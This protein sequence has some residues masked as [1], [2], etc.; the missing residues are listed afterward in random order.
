MDW[1]SQFKTSVDRELASGLLDSLILVPQST[2]LRDIRALLEAS[3]H[4]S[5]HPLGL[6]AAREVK[7][8]TYFPRDKRR[9]PTSV[10]GRD[11]GSEGM[12]AT[13]ITD[14]CRER[15]TAF[16]NHP[17]FAKLKKDACDRIIIVDDVS[18]SG[19]RVAAMMRAIRR[20]PTFRSWYS[21]AWITFGIV[22]YAVTQSAEDF[23]RKAA[24]LR[25]G[26]PQLHPL[27]V[28]CAQ[29]PEWWPRS[30]S[31]EEEKAVEE[32]CVTYGKEHKIP[33]K[34]HKGYR[35][36]MAR[37]VFE[38]SCPNN[39]PGLLW[40][41]TRTWRPLFPNRSVPLSLAPLFDSGSDPSKQADRARAILGERFDPERHLLDIKDA[42]LLL[43]LATLR[44]KIRSVDRIANV[45]SLPAYVVH[46]LLE[47]ANKH[48]YV[49]PFGALTGSGVAELRHATR[50]GRLATEPPLRGD[51]M[52]YPSQ[53]RAARKPI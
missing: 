23:V 45:L 44:K 30:L 28:R 11:V 26:K 7:E 50:A 25:H 6:Y 51:A 16:V 8:A 17:S 38:R 37:I 9:K 46:Q 47:K 29:R 4:D 1:L 36:G 31:V 19:M 41:K 14:L 27:S 39:A 52:Y 22:A 5:K 21:F 49:D 42:N 34:F 53:L 12:I 35:A 2:F 33:W 40:Y 32:L 20:S 3:A 24:R 10:V 15:P 48:G 13:L 43:L 18:L